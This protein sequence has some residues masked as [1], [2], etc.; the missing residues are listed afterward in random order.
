MERTGVITFKGGSL[1]LLGKEV[2]V[3]D[4]APDF[5][6]VNN[7]LQP[8]SLKDFAGRIVIISAVPSLDTPVCEAQTRRFN[9]EAARLNAAVLTISMDLPFAQ[10][11][12]CAAH[13]IQG[14]Q[15]LSDYQERSFAQAWGLL[16]KE[17]KLIARAVII[18]DKDRRVAYIAIVQEVTSQPDYDRALAA[19]RALGA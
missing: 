19:A 16:I 2:K 7:A 18:I 13:D 3:G 11:R 17:L 15:I 9:E 4:K 6:C 10:G 8:V 1:T 5:T 12:F 14:V